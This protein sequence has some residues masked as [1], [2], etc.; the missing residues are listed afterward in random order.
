MATKA[1]SGTIWL[2]VL[3]AKHS[4]YHET[5]GEIVTHDFWPFLKAMP[6][7]D[8]IVLASSGRNDFA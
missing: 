2:W 7:F 1:C 5:L 8:A 6:R 4:D 3:F